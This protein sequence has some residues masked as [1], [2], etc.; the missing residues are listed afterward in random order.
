MV[1]ICNE[2]KKKKS[3]RKRRSS[4]NM[5][6]NLADIFEPLWHVVSS[7]LSLEAMK[8]VVLR[9]ARLAKYVYVSF[10]TS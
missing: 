7:I 8:F 4:S 5:F 10:R 3:K 1:G 2:Q 9:G 6:T